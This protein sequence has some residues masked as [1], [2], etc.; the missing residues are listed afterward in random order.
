MPTVGFEPAISARERPRNYALD[1]AATGI[2]KLILMALN[3]VLGLQ[4]CDTAK[5]EA[6]LLNRTWP[7]IKSPK[8]RLATQFLFSD[9]EPARITPGNRVLW[10]AWSRRLKPLPVE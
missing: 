3:T 5:S 8:P 1:R 10:A 4:G 6:H 2:G 7:N 9:P